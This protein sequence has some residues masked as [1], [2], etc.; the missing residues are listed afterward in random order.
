MKNKNFR[1]TNEVE[2]EIV[3]PDTSTNIKAWIPLILAIIYA[4]SP[5]DLVPDVIPALG[6]FE[7]AL[8]L[9]TG[10][11]NGIEKNMLE[12][13]TTL[14]SIVKFIKWGLFLVGLLV[15]AI[16]VLIVVVIWKVVV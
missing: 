1:K 6:W 7:D 13:N 14:R 5:I 4:V 8:F 12:A 15:I 2:T 16:I 9:V 3:K 10:G 11:L